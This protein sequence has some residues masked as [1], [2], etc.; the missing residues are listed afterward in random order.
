MI[1]QHQAARFAFGKSHF[2]HIATSLI[3]CRLNR[4]CHYGGLNSSTSSNSSPSSLA[5]VKS[6][7]PR[8]SLPKPPIPTVFNDGKFLLLN[9]NNAITEQLCKVV[10]TVSDVRDVASTYFG[11]IHLWFPILSESSYYKHLPNTFESPHADYSLLSLSMALIN[12]IPAAKDNPDTLSPMYALLKTSIAMV[13]AANINTLA[14]IRARLLVSLFEVG[15]GIPAA[16]LSLAATARAAVLAGLNR[17]IHNASSSQREEDL[18]VWW[19][20]VMLDR[21]YT[22]ERGDGGPGA[23]QDLGSPYHLPKDS[24]IRDHEV[25]PSSKYLSLSGSLTLS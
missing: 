20:I 10:G 7:Q 16:Y 21:Y 19:G 22:L 11:T 15:H 8:L 24:N 5:V 2:I 13:E 18:R 23:T 4:A 12:T 1:G 3:A 17:A 9:I 14:V 25:S 6:R